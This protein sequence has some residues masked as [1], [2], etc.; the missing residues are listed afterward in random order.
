MLRK[1]PS[2]LSLQGI[3]AT[4]GREHPEGEECR[5][6]APSLRRWAAW[7][8]LLLLLPLVGSCSS[9]PVPERL[10]VYAAASLMDVLDALADEYVAAGGMRPTFHFAGSRTLARQ[11]AAGAPADLMISSDKATIAELEGYGH[12]TPNS[13]IRICGNQLV[14]VAPLPPEDGGEQAAVAASPAVGAWSLGDG[15]A[16]AEIGA[17]GLL[18]YQRVAIADPELAPAGAY[19]MRWLESQG[20]AEIL[21]PRLVPLA[22]VRATVAAVAAGHLPVG[23]VYSTDAKQADERVQ[24]LHR[25]GPGSDFEVEYFAALIQEPGTNERMHPGTSFTIFLAS[26]E[27]EE[28]FERFGFLPRKTGRRG[29]GAVP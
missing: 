16:G 18:G 2:T 22:D 19:T 6:R 26:T 7:A 17:H 8:C 24:I 9:P 21:R 29:L 5:R 11:I 1:S 3:A 15:A 20:I 14:V 28:V 25:V 13:S 12:I 27:A 10:L 23:V 4:A